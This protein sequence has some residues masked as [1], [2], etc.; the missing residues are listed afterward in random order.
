MIKILKAL[1]IFFWRLYMKRAPI[2][3]GTG[4]PYERDPEN[5]CKWYE[6]FKRGKWYF[7]NCET[8]GHYLC[9]GCIHK[10]KYQEKEEEEDDAE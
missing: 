4:I 7:D 3:H 5:P 6:P 9:E 2:P 1:A 10:K 8:D